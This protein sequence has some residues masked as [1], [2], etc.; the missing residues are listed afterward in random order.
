MNFASPLAYLS[1]PAKNIEKKKEQS[2]SDSSEDVD[3]NLNVFVVTF[4]GVKNAEKNLSGGDPYVC[5]RCKAILNKFS[6]LVK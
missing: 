4:E 1:I 2:E 5:K 3:L 6:V